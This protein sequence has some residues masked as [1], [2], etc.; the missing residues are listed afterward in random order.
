MRPE[1]QKRR[2][3]SKAGQPKGYNRKKLS[4]LAS[5]N[6]SIRARNKGGKPK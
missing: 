2:V 6:A 4:N 5:T 3:I 1:G